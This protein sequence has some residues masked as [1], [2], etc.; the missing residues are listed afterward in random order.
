MICHSD[1]VWNCQEIIFNVTQTQE[2]WR[3]SKGWFWFSVCGCLSKHGDKHCFRGS[4][5]GCREAED[6][7]KK[8]WRVWEILHQCTKIDT[9][10]AAYVTIL[11]DPSLVCGVSTP[12]FSI[13]LAHLEPRPRRSSTRYFYFK[14]QQ[15]QVSQAEQYNVVETI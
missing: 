3:T 12:P 8:N 4:K 13:S 5:V 1:A 9:L 10:R 11:S 7:W 15:V 14:K 6:C 2:E